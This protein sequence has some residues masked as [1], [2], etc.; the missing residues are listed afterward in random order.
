[1]K[2]ENLRYRAGMDYLTAR[3]LRK[4]LEDNLPRLILTR[5]SRYG[6]TLIPNQSFL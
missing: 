3:H 1:M 4:K 2:L 5:L 6:N